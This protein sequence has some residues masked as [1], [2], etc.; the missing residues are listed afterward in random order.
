MSDDGSANRIQQETRAGEGAS[1]D[2]SHSLK[3]SYIYS[4]IRTFLLLL[5]EA[6][7]KEGIGI[8]RVSVSVQILKR[9]FR[10]PN[11][12]LVII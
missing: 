7:R 11:T 10:I 4:Y 1:I 2:M 9:C 12:V 6:S 8:G 3:P 5:V